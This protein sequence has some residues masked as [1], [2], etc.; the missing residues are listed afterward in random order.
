MSPC[1]RKT[2]RWINL[3][4]IKKRLHFKPQGIFNLF[5]NRSGLLR[6]SLHESGKPVDWTC[7]PTSEW[8]CLNP[9]FRP[10]V[11]KTKH[12]RFVTTSSYFDDLLS[13]M[14]KKFQVNCLNGSEDVLHLKKSLDPWCL[15]WKTFTNLRYLFNV[16]QL[17]LLKLFESI[18]SHQFYICPG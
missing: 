15:N 5:E 6:K 2:R 14:R 7:H 8:L 3:D 4:I 10:Q 9:A 1:Q 18:W 13:R 12:L 17:N 11:Y 16:G